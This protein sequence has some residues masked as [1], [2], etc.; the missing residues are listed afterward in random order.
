MGLK[1]HDWYLYKRN[2]REIWTDIVE[3]RWVHEG[4]GRDIAKWPQAKG[5][6][7]AK[8]GKEG[9]SFWRIWSSTALLTPWFQTSGLQDT[10]RTNLCY[11]KPANLYQLVAIVLGNEDKFPERKKEFFVIFFKSLQRE[12]LTFC[13]RAWLSHGSQDPLSYPVSPSVWDSQGRIHWSREGSKCPQEP[14]GKEISK[15]DGEL[16]LLGR[17]ATL[18]G[19]G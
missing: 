9:P 7:A 11:F 16:G 3:R 15:T 19:G 12:W 10:E 8:G 14:G 4:G 2:E 17:L 13:P 5:P 18:V 6:P 1:S